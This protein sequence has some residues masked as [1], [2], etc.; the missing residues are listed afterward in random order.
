MQCLEE[1]YKDLVRECF[2]K[3]D[4]NSINEDKKLSSENA[5]NNREN[6]PKNGMF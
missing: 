4:Y 5:K 1:K 2:L 6:I 3:D